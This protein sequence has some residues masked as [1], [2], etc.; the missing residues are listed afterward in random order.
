[1]SSS[2]K[3][4]NKAL[5]EC[6]MPCVP[7][8]TKIGDPS[9][10]KPCPLSLLGPSNCY[11]LQESENRIFTNV[12][13]D[14]LYNNIDTYM[15]L[16][17]EQITRNEKLC[18]QIAGSYSFN[19]RVTGT[20]D[21]S[22]YAQLLYQIV[23]N[24]DYIN[25]KNLIIKFYLDRK[26]Y[27]TGREKSKQAIFHIS[28]HPPLPKYY[29]DDKHSRGGCGFFRRI[30]D[31]TSIATNTCGSEVSFNYTIDSIEWGGNKFEFGDIYRPQRSFKITGKAL[32]G[33]FVKMDVSENFDDIFRKGFTDGKKQPN[34]VQKN[35]LNALHRDLHN[36][37]VEFWNNVMLTGTESQTSSSS[38]SSNTA[39]RGIRKLGALKGGKRKT[40][41]QKRKA[42]KYTRKH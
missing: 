19:P 32:G 5:E 1:M 17:V 29:T 10:K 9:V 42:K 40:R 11:L 25:C 30:C 14:I 22:K 4:K 7:E 33:E 20:I 39:I 13:W 3:S 6:D 24:N 21:P 2:S 31:N 16:F 28:L 27:V 23:K 41:K 8:F 37:F 36:E 34:D 18:D 26:E 35:L 12:D 38:S 15:K